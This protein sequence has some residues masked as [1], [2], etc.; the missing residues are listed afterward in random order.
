MMIVNQVVSG[1]SSMVFRGGEEPAEDAGQTDQEV[2]VAAA[3]GDGAQV[4]QQDDQAPED[5]QCEHQDG[6]PAGAFLDVLGDRRGVPSGGR[7][8][9]FVLLRGAGPAVTR[10]RFL[11]SSALG[12]RSAAG[13][14]FRRC[15][16]EPV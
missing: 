13:F 14:A 3:S 12:R 7:D 2:V 8:S 11:G 10:S 1:V 5:E 4:V 6:H 9:V 15:H 16:E